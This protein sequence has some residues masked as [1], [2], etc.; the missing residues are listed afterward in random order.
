MLQRVTD[1]PL[2][3]HVVNHCG[4]HVFMNFKKQK[5][6]FDTPVPE[7]TDLTHTHT[8]AGAHRRTHAR[9]CKEA[10]MRDSK[11][12]S[13]I[14]LPYWK[15]CIIVYHTLWIFAEINYL[16][17]FQTGSLQLSFSMPYHTLTLLISA[18][19]AFSL[20]LSFVLGLCCATLLRQ[21]RASAGKVYSV[22]GV[23]RKADDF[24]FYQPCSAF[25]R[26]NYDNH[27]GFRS[28][29]ILWHVD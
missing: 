24:K 26:S 9:A 10:R 23:G 15:F 13:Q 29:G 20:S 17:H 11:P 8:R 18:Y 2:S 5:N 3:D 4:H 25:R 21:G 16:H 7:T 28:S 6:G 14:E 22:D 1:F 27:G 12:Q 19:I